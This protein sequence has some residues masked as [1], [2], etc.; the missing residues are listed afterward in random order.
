MC[1]GSHGVT[2][3]SRGTSHEA[4]W[5]FEWVTESESHLKWLEASH[6]WLESYASNYNNQ[7][8]AQ[9]RS[10]VFEL[11]TVFLRRYFDVNREPVN[12]DQ[13][14]WFHTEGLPLWENLWYLY[15][16]KFFYTVEQSS[17]LHFCRGS[18]KQRWHD[19]R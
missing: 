3:P 10:L 12:V 2:S 19:I 9:N 7:K 8:W 11:N 1:R 14:L 4:R 18:S 15:K 16:R 13:F 5:K 17:I 6:V